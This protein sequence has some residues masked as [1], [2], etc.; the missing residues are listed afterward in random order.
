[1]V[2]ARGR[3]WLR[4]AFGLGTVLLIIQSAAVF[5]AGRAWLEANL[6]FR[7]VVQD[8]IYLLAAGLVLARALLVRQDRGAWLLMAG[9]LAFYAAGTVYW[10]AVLAHIS[11]T[12]YPSVSDFM[13]LA[14]YP[15]AY[16]AVLRLLRA[17]E[18][19]IRLSSW[20]DGVIAAAC[21]AAYASVV[22]LGGVTV[23]SFGSGLTMLVSIAYPM[24]DIVLAGVLLGSW[25]LSN[26]RL[27]RVWTLLLTGMGINT[28][29]NGLRMLQT[30]SG[31]YTPSGWVDVLWAVA[32]A[33]IAAAAWR[34]PGAGAQQR[35]ARAMVGMLLPAV[36]AWASMLLL[37]SDSWRHRGLSVISG[38]LAATAI[39]GA[40]V[41]MLLTVRTVEKLSDA[42]RQART[43]DLTGLP[44]RR[45][46]LEILRRELPEGDGGAPMAVAIIDLD[47]FKEINDSFGHDLGD[48][49][50]QMVAARLTEAVGDDGELAR[51]GGDE[52]GVIMRDAD[53]AGA[54]KIALGLLTALRRPFDLDQIEL[55]VDASIGVAV[56]PD[57]GADHS[58]LLRQAGNAMYAAKN[59]HRGVALATGEADDVAGRQRLTTLEEL[60][61]GLDRGELTLHYQPQMHLASG[62]V[63]GVEALVR[64]EHPRR[65][66]VFPDVF[67]PLAE[68]AGLM[69]RLTLQVLDIALAQCRDWRAAG[70]HLVV[71]VNLSASNL[72]DTTLPGHVADAL[73]RYDVPPAALH[74]EVTEEILMRDAARA[75]AVLA[76]LRAMGVRLAVDDYGTGYSS[77]AY[78]HALPVDDLKLDRAFVTHCDS[79]PRSAAIVKSTVELAHNL[80][81]R[82]IAEGVESEAA[83]DRLREWGCDLVQGYHLS[84]PQSA[85]RF[86]AWLDE[87]YPRR[88]AEAEIALH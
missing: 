17:R 5:P 28:T 85:D 59:D 21:A 3:W 2:P 18:S 24:A 37:V 43:D 48:R 63:T 53:T 72:Q 71:A 36:L 74:L 84:R 26:W 82:M 8:G 70:L 6:G 31:V 9:G 27:D 60:R 23:D 56:H 41:R 86:T 66:L 68:H 11:P 81:M 10:V 29:A 88:G 61:V 47:R 78:L 49:L 38:G 80:G 7:T 54:Q 65:G 25:A 34:C 16:A 87:R 1:M 50:L 20:L 69:G 62:T 4:A 79:D 64:W 52:F 19:R 15:F 14:Y 77:L 55:H 57:H 40:I 73:S 12:P 67:L 58:M 30:T 42:R 33:L 75:T 76:E 35:P 13:W 51:L 46:F 45:R 39:T 32:L 22:F 83:L 44:N